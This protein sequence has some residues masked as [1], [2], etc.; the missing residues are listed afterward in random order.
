MTL[1]DKVFDLL[2]K[3]RKPLTCTQI[4]KELGIERG[5]YGYSTLSGCLHKMERDNWIRRVANIGPRKGIGYTIQK[6]GV[7]KLSKEEFD[8]F[9]NEWYEERRKE[10]QNG[11]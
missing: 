2:C 4:A 8:K 3:N 1:S 7:P 11:C 10:S 6:T 9:L 5:P